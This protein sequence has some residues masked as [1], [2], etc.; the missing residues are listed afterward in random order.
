MSDHDS[1]GKTK[2]FLG[3]D[4]HKTVDYA[5]LTTILIG[6]IQ[7]Q[8]TQIENLDKFAHEPQNYKDKCDEMEKR[9]IELE[10]KLEEL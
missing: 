8:Q 5:K 3:G 4:T 6:S 1:I 7:E 10:K 9:I 2:E